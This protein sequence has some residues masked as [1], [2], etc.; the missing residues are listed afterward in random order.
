MR[1]FISY[2][3]VDVLFAAD[4]TEELRARGA[5]V[6]FAPES[7]GSGDSFVGAIDAALASCNLGVLVWSAAAKVSPW[8]TS[9][10]EALIVR[11]TQEGL[12][13]HLVRLD[14]TPTPATLSAIHEIRFRAAPSAVEAA[15]ALAGKGGSPIISASQEAPPAAAARR[16]PVELERLCD[17]DLRLLAAHVHAAITDV[18]ARTVPPVVSPR[19]DPQ[20]RLLARLDIVNL[21]TNGARDALGGSLELIEIHRKQV[22][23]ARRQMAGPA[24]EVINFQLKVDQHEE[25][26]RSETSALRDSLKPLVEALWELETPPSAAA[27]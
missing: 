14:A 9:E 25:G 26:I 20:T 17:A 7:I 18:A 8:V 6:F 23:F 3:S 1:C 24:A 10:R 5:E 19:I 2:S 11:R 22:L 4:L 16:R 15:A 27:T 12:R 13:L 21:T